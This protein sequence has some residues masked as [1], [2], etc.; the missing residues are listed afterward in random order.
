MIIFHAIIQACIVP[1]H[2]LLMSF[3]A[4]PHTH[5]FHLSRCEI[6][7]DSASG[8]IQIAAHIFIDDLELAIKQTGVHSLY[9]CTP[10][11][12]AKANAAIEAYL[13]QKLSFYVN[14]KKVTPELLGKEASEDMMAVWCYFEIAGYKNLRQV[15][16][17]NKILTEVFNDQKNIV[18]VTVDKRKKG[19]AIFDTNRIEEVFSW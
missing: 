8:D 13:N 18:D 16:I 11:E 7:Y 3:T 1:F 15:K 2:V 10:K 17:E 9:I 4:S 19:F 6:N 14:G 12:S 5:D